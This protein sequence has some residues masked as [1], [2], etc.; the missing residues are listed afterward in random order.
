MGSLSGLVNTK[1]R[2]TFKQKL[3]QQEK[4]LTPFDKFFTW[5]QFCHHGGHAKHIMDWF[6][7]H[8]LCP[9]YKCGCR[10]ASLD[11]GTKQAQ[12]S[13]KNSLNSEQHKILMIESPNAQENLPTQVAG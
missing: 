13:L 5:C 9:V 4:K 2:S 8:Q 12:L 10:C 7:N 6:T 3:F 1:D 11:P